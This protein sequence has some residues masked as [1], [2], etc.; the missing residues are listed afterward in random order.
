M[1]ILRF[2]KGDIYLKINVINSD[3]FL[4]INFNAHLT[5]EKSKCKVGK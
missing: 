5:M 4:K 1:I 3:L 2:V